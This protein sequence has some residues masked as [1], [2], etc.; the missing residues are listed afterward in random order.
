[1]TDR[2]TWPDFCSAIVANV[3]WQL[4]VSATDAEIVAALERESGVTGWTVKTGGKETG[5]ESEFIDPPKPAGWAAPERC[6]VQLECGSGC[7]R[8]KGHDGEHLGAC[9]DDGPGSCPA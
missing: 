5:W 4:E 6:G 9:D 8:P 1:M 7:F 3:E 2:L